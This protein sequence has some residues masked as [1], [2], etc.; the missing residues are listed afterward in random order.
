[1]LSA[2]N[3]NVL[4]AVQRCVRLS[5]YPSAV[6]VA[7]FTRPMLSDDEVKIILRLLAADGYVSSQQVSSPR[8]N[9]SYE[10][11]DRGRAETDRVKER[12]HA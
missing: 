8:H 5:N 4:I 10:L 3:E 6:N 7:R 2:A 9:A 11:T 1:M 12:A